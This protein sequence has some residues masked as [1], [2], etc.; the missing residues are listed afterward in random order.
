VID[1][2][3]LRGSVTDWRSVSGGWSNRVFRLTTSE[4]CY[5]V[6]Q[7]RNPWGIERWDD[8]L[9]EAFQLELRAIDAGVQAP[10]PV[11]SPQTGG[12][13]AWVPGAGA[14][15]VPVRVHQ[16]VDAAPLGTGVVTP[17]T[18]RWVGRTL[19]ILHGL[20]ARAVDRSLFPT[21]NASAAR[22][23]PELTDA[24]QRGRAAW[25]GLM[26][27]AAPSAVLVAELT[28]AAGFHPDEEIMSHSDVDQ[29]NILGPA[30]G[31]VLCDWD[32]A[33]PVVPRRE[34]ADVAVSMGCWRDFRIARE[35]VRSYHRQGGDDAGFAPEDLAPALMNSLDWI[36]VN[37]ERA[38]GLRPA[39][40]TEIAQAGQLLP[41]LLTAMPS[42]VGT[43]QRITELL[44]I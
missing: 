9:A 27:A 41:A 39:D 15:A 8:W 44:R 34:L 17:E 26:A 42:E 40:A 14:D 37:A 10:A 30:A 13:L 19:A 1:A 18:A 36:T 5:A 2:F 12:C 21:P 38:L 25:A 11:A 6:K 28:R 32:V 24:A 33:S 35:V 16:W 29:K 43:A 20:R 7:M 4:G 3:G 22:R 23:W 31:P